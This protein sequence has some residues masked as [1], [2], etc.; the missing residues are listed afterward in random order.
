MGEREQWMVAVQARLERVTAAQDLSPVLEE[1]ALTEARELARTLTDD[2]DSL[3][4][5]YLLGW[6]HW[7]RYQ[8]LPEGHDQQALQAAVT[9]F[10]ACF[11]SGID[12]LPEPLFPLL[13]DHAAIA[14][15]ELLGRPQRSDDQRLF[16]AAADIWQRILTYTPSDHPDRSRRLSNLGV[17]LQA[18]FEHTGAEEDLDAAITYLSEAVQATPSGHPRRAMY[19]SDLGIALRIRFG[20]AGVAGDLAAAITY[21]RDAVQATPTD[22]PKRL[23]RLSNLGNA[24]ITRYE[25]TEAPADVEAAITYFRQAVQATPADHPNRATYLS[26]LGVAL[27]SRITHTGVGDLDAAII[28]LQ[29]AVRATPT[30]HPER[31]AHQS[32]LGSALLSRFERSAVAEDLDA[33]IDAGQQ[34]LQATPVGHPERAGRLS[35]LAGALSARF[36]RTGATADLDTAVTCLREA[37]QAPPAGH[38]DRARY[39]S[40]LGV[41]LQ[42]RFER[43]GGAADLDTAVTRLREAVQATPAGHPDRAT[44]LSNLGNALRI[45]F[46]RTSAAEDL[47][48]AI[49]AGQQAVQAT[50]AGHPDRAMRRSNL[51]NALHRRFERTRAAEDLNDAIEAGQQAVQATPTGHPECA[52]YLLN[53]GNAL[54]TR[55]EHTGAAK[56][57]NDAIVYFRQAVR[58]TPV[59]HPDRALYL[60]NLGNALQTR[61][62]HTGA[63][64]DLNDAFQGYTEAAN[65]DAAAPSTRIGAGRAA[66]SL[67]ARTDP[68]LAASLLK[69]AVL[70]LPEVAPRFLE[71]G[72]QQHAIGRFDGLAAAAAA[73]T[74]SDPAVPQ[75]QRPAQALRLLEAARGVLLSQVLNTR[76]DL[77]ELRDHNPELAERFVELRD[78]LDRP[79]SAADTDLA[80]LPSERTANAVQRTIRDRRQADAEFTQ[81]LVRVRSL[82]GFGAFGLPPSAEQ[83]EAQAEPGPVVMFNISAYRS[84]A[85]LLTSG[86]I[87]SQHLPGLDQATVGNQV[88]AF[89]QALSTIAIAESPLDRVAAQRTLRQVLAWLWD[90]AAEP[91][92][93]TLG[94]QESPAPGQPWPRLWWIPGGMLSLLPIHAAGHHTNP[95]DP[96]H[97]TVMDRVISSYTPTVRALTHART[98]LASAPGP[99]GRSLIVAMST[100]P[101]LPHDGRLAYVSAEA[102]LL[103]ALLPHPVL[104]AEPP[105]ANDTHTD[106]IPTKA[107]VL[108]HLPGCAIAHFACHGF[109]DPADPSQSRLLLHDHRR[110]PLTVAAM[111]PLALDHTQLAYLSACSTTRVSD[112]RLL[113]EAIHLTSAFQLAGFPHVVGTLWEIDDAIA[114]HIA[115]TFYTA[116]A[117]SGGTLDPHRA[118]HALHHATRTQRDRQPA[119]PYL[120]ASHIHAG[121]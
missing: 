104:L 25:Q 28:Y 7:C 2:P 65:M 19:L 34:A 48:D 80:V 52:G 17:T 79:S 66:A 44:Y 54:Q 57:L 33:A 18:R 77:S 45:R 53:L 67:V 69:A 82:K 60:S 47:D 109:T 4:S 38:P 14:A 42:A 89:H 58:D 87:T 11:I 68:G 8:A 73:M 72:D 70:L 114:V 110:D 88:L 100:T 22:H 119:T 62:E 105:A 98:T 92:L 1:T 115:D 32:N 51:G 15:T 43:A 39:L 9:M 76:S 75:I 63:A 3:S 120:W 101:G 91:V 50:P 94:Y 84:D 113:D 29:E 78:W 16:E 37:V 90:N 118:A 102:A 40:N 99:T 85:I 111:A 71:R 121:A 64:K 5:R 13:A 117:D 106:Q 24:L 55:F 21:F 107:N 74:L 20:Y 49:E 10:S 41:T 59:D 103:K 30:D 61:F 95:P 31:P 6:L 86:G 23:G 35:T 108:K 81:L 112:T 36:G 116:L 27:V 26:N 46:E 56:D 83:L 12:G 96:G 97:R 93:N